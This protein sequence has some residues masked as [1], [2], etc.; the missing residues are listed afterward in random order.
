MS[1]L[2]GSLKAGAE[3]IF[4]AFQLTHVLIPGITPTLLF[5]AP[6]RF[7][8]LLGFLV[9]SL[10]STLNKSINAVLEMFAKHLY[11][12][13]IWERRFGPGWVRTSLYDKKKYFVKISIPGQWESLAS[14]FPWR[15][16][17]LGEGHV[18]LDSLPIHLITPGW[19]TFNCWIC[20]R[21]QHYFV[22]WDK[23]SFS[24]S[25]HSFYFQVPKNAVNNNLTNMPA[26]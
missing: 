1:I 15:L 4:F 21:K 9:T 13:R 10:P 6:P 26:I 8:V 14:P 2:R 23:T 3:F 25:S 7:A 12:S 16:S 20:E 11:V 17:T 19:N 24:F 18:I 5:F 22:A